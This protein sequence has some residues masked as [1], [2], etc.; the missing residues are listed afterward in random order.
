MASIQ[1]TVQLSCPR[2]FP[3]LRHNEV[4]DAVANW[5]SEVCND[6]CTEPTLQPITGEILTGASAIR[7]DGARLNIAV[8]GFWG[9]HYEKKFFMSKSST[10][11]PPQTSSKASQQRTKSTGI[12]KSRLMNRECGKWSTQ[13]LHTLGDVPLWWLCKCSH[14]MLQEARIDA[15]SLTVSHLL[16]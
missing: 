15:G 14:C 12:A 13:L 3:T 9:G 10:H 7:E 16:I 5:T 2:G 11:M 1:H 4:N 6:V 8:N